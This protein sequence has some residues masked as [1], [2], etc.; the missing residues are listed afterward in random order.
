MVGNKSAKKEMP[1]VIVTDSRGSSQGIPFFDIDVIA[2]ASSCRRRI[3]AKDP[4]LTESMP[5]MS[6]VRFKTVTF[7]QIESAEKVFTLPKFSLT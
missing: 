5:L 3:L 4:H 6:G 2:R 1:Q 7:V